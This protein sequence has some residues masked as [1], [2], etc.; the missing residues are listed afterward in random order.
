M[1]DKCYLFGI[2]VALLPT[3][4]IVTMFV[5]QKMTPVTSADPAQQ[6]MMMVMPLIFGIMFYNLPPGLCFTGSP[7]I[8]SASSSRLPSTNGWLR[9]RTSS[10]SRRRQ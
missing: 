2:P 5:L 8:S 1:P 10:P 4:M 6:R 9:P 3:V 7:A